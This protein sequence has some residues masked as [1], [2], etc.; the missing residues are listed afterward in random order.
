MKA[1]KTKEMWVT[2]ARGASQGIAHRDRAAALREQDRQ[3]CQFV[4]V[5]VLRVHVVGRLKRA[6]Q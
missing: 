1:A 3:A 2:L 6:A 4:S 5:A